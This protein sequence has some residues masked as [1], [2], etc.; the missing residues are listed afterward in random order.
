VI[1]QEQ[2]G[3]EDGRRKNNKNIRRKKKR[4]RNRI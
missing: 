3:W 4:L 1:Q 2:K